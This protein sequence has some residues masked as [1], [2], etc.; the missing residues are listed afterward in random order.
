MTVTLASADSTRQ[1]RDPPLE[2]LGRAERSKAEFVAAALENWYSVYGR[3][4]EWRTW[5]DE[6]RLAVVEVLLQRTRAETVARFAPDF[7]RRYPD[8]MSLGQAQL[9]ELEAV[10]APIGLH[11]R[12]AAS[13]RS[14]ALWVTEEKGDAGSR[15]APGVGQ[16]VSRAVAVSG[17]KSAV[18]M[19][20]SNWVRVLRRVF[21]GRWM[22]DYRYDRRL[23]SI[24]HAVV[25]AGT[26]ARFVNWAVLDVGA[27]ICVPREPR[28]VL[29][30]LN[31]QCH[32]AR[33]GVEA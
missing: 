30:P 5:T 3:T 12:R 26:D 16:Y 19:V 21:G 18:A 25:Q 33:G 29:C 28:C 20:D 9:C 7:F 14:L 10:L 13:L 11:R 15:D 1:R 17:R 2:A 8:W 27:T 24:A 22:S 23:Q 31:Q 32:Y 4:F 6:Y